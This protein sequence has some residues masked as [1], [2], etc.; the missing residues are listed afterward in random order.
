MEMFLFLDAWHFSEESEF[1]KNVFIQLKVSSSVENS[2]EGKYLTPKYTV[3]VQLY[4]CIYS[5]V[6]PR[7]AIKDIGL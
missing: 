1:S 4:I 6:W 7:V 2:F 3:R 5:F